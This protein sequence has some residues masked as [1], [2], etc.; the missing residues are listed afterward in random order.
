MKT[1]IKVL[2][3]FFVLAILSVTL[4]SFVEA[5]PEGENNGIEVMI[6][7]E[8]AR[9]YWVSDCSGELEFFF[10]ESVTTQY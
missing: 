9:W 4:S 3:S 2:L 10:A 7:K 1:K 6:D 5:N 8:N